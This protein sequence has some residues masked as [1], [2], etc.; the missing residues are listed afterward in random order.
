MALQ[1]A[2]SVIVSAVNVGPTGLSPVR[3]PIQAY[4]TTQCQNGSEGN[5]KTRI[6]LHIVV[7]CT[8]VKTHTDSQG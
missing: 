7:D 1:L 2:L 6:M 8:T 5:A 4:N 3:Y